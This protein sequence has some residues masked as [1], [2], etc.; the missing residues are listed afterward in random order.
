MGLRHYNASHLANRVPDRVDGEHLWAMAAMWRV[1]PAG[2]SPVILDQE[3]MVSVSGPACFWC[4]QIPE[5]A[6]QRCPGVPQDE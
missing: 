6:S 5:A 4:H 3:N 1:N 2:A